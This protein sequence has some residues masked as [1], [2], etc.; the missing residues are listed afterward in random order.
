MTREFRRLTLLG[1]R[2]LLTSTLN[3]EEIKK[4]Y[5]FS[6]IHKSEYMQVSYYIVKENHIKFSPWSNNRV[7]MTNSLA[8]GEK[9]KLSYCPTKKHVN[10]G[11]RTTLKI[12]PLFIHKSIQWVA[13]PLPRLCPIKHTLDRRQMNHHSTKS[14]YLNWNLQ[15]VAICE[16][17]HGLRVLESN[18][19]NIF[20]GKHA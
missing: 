20:G 9:T 15:V 6:K 13:Q 12:N 16:N 7:V 19:C 10:E 4:I 2:Q 11:L 18:S 8:K 5:N 14:L 17:V 1:R 3:F